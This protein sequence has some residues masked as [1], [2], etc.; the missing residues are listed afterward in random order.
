MGI[1][2][3]ALMSFVEGST[4]SLF[5]IYNL[6]YGVFCRPND[7]SKHIG[8]AIGSSVLDLTF[9][10]E[11][12]LLTHEAGHTYFNHGALN[13]FAARGPACWSIIRRRIQTLLSVDNHELQGNQVLLKTAL[14][15]LDEVTMCTPF[16]IEGFSDFYASEYHATN[17]GRLFRGNAQALLPNW[18]HLPVGYNGR[19][20]TVFVS[21]TSITRPKGLVQLPSEDA[22]CFAATKKLDFEL[23]MGV[24]V[25]VGN[26]DGHPIPV[27]D[28]GAHLFGLVLLNDWSARDIQA[29]EYQPL[30]PFLSKSFGT[31]ISPWVVPMEALRDAMVPLREQTP[32][33]VDYLY[34]TS[35]KLPDIQL[36]VEIQPRGSRIRTLLAETNCKELYWSM[37]QMLA[38]HTVN[39]CIMKPGDLLGTG[40]ISGPERENWGSLL[41][42][43]LNGT[44]TIQL[45]DGSE[46]TFLEDGDTVI[47]TGY[48]QIGSH[49]IGFGVLEGTILPAS[50]S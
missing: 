28:A 21:G 3:S 10:E 13:A 45:D 17:V 40:T 26:P 9:L 47:M 16:K 32:K 6:P 31:S 29:Y 22:P 20:S 8:V 7:E 44:Q 19:A 36:K 11:K 35:P 48:C 38:H 2:A 1:N 15:P 24:F 30:G 42:I 41:E 49:K 18:K 5:S 23:E 27:S 39:H 43:S 4:D 50:N 37:E 46:R 14:I 12:G 25:G 33:P 34:Q